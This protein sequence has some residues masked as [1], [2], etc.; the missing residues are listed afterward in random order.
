MLPSACHHVLEEVAEET[1]HRHARK[2]N[3]AHHAQVD[4]SHL[5]ALV[6][7]VVLDH[8]P[9]CSERSHLTLR[10]VVVYRIVA[11]LTVKEKAVFEVIEVA[12][13]Q[14]VQYASTFPQANA[15]R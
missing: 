7:P 8:F 13:L 11:V 6:A 15:C 9:Q 12:P 4:R 14:L 2:L 5:R 1:P 3:R 10:E